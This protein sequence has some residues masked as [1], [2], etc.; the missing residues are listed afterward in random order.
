MLSYRLLAIAAAI[1]PALLPRLPAQCYQRNMGCTSGLTFGN[2]NTFAIHCVDTA[3]RTIEGLT[4]RC[5]GLGGGGTGTIELWFAD[6]RGKPTYRLT[7]GTIRI[8]SGYGNHSG[9]FASAVRIPANAH[10]AVVITLNS[11]THPICKT[12]VRQTHWWH[13]PT[14]SKW[15][16]PYTQWAWAF[17]V[18]CRAGPK[19]KYVPYGTGCPGSRTVCNRGVP[20]LWAQ[21]WPRIGQTLKLHVECTPPGS[22]MVLL[23]GASSSSW[24]GV[25]LP[26]N[27]G[28]LGAPRCSV[29]AS[30]EGQI[31]GRTN[32][33]GQIVVSVPIPND[34]FLLGKRFY[35]QAVVFDPKAQGGLALSQG[36]GGADRN[37][38]ERGTARPLGRHFPSQARG[39]RTKP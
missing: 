16:G 26:L 37:P 9:K 36:P 38:S 28:F 20:R 31:D 25:R 4:L 21:W 39:G 19:G 13:S 10:Y 12:G 33:Q 14:S 32:A 11:S 1:A 22:S 5:A 24:G 8:A 6:S 17:R 30:G 27:L 35:N 18:D 15:Q 23:F 7:T 29:L 3:S 34:P 2:G